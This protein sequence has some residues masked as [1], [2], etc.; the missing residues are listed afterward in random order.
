MARGISFAVPATGHTRHAATP[1]TVPTMGT[2]IGLFGGGLQQ[3]LTNHTDQSRAFHSSKDNFARFLP[4]HCDAFPIV[5][6][7]GGLWQSNDACDFEELAAIVSGKGAR[8][9]VG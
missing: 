2:L 4:Q 8:M 6:R 5:A 7:L 1:D 3:D 9:P